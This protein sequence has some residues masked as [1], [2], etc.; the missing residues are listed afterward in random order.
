TT[1]DLTGIAGGTY[2]VTV[3]DA[4]LDTTIDVVKI[5]EPDLIS[6]SLASVDSVSYL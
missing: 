6:V 4:D 5:V 1:E 3:I 2:T